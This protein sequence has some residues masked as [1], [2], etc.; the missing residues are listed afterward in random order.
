MRKAIRMWPLQAPDI[1]VWGLFYLG[2]A[3]AKDRSLR[4][5]LQRNTIHVG[6]AE[7]CDLLIFNYRVCW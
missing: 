5:L 7:G 6:T 1:R 2:R 4:Q 3:K